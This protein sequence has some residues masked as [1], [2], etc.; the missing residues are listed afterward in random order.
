MPKQVRR[1][2]ANHMFSKD[3][4]IFSYTTKQAVADGVLIKADTEHSSQAAIRSGL[5]H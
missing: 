4:I 1:A 5:F 3:D 2:A